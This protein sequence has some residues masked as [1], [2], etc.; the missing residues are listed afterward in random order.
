MKKLIKILSTLLAICCIT[1]LF[2]ACS[3]K[4]NDILYGSYYSIDNENSYIVLTDETITFYNVDF[5]LLEE[6]I[7]YYLGESVDVSAILDGAQHYEVSINNDKIFVDVY[8]DI[9]LNVYYNSDEKSLTTLER[10]YILRE[11]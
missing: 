11:V 8:K 9:A 3:K 7:L 5:T 6:D 10:K 1:C 4:D 2:A